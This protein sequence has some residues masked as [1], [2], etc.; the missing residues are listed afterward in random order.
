MP[1]SRQGTAR[2]AVRMQQEAE[3]SRLRGMVF[4]VLRNAQMRSNSDTTVTAPRVSVDELK[5]SIA[6]LEAV[7]QFAKNNPHSM[8]AWDKNSKSHVSHMS[9]GDFYGSEVS[10]SMPA[11]GIISIQL[12]NKS[13]DVSVDDFRWAWPLAKR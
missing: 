2:M 4:E 6:A 1:Q 12:K 11:D 10:V 13:G 7:K 5:A 3:R 9:Q 8:G